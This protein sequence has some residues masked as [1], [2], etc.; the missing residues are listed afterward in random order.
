[1]EQHLHRKLEDT[2]LKWERECVSQTYSASPYSILTWRC[3]QHEACHCAGPPRERH[4]GGYAE[5][6]LGEG[7]EVE[8]GEGHHNGEPDSGVSSSV[9]WVVSAAVLIQRRGT[10]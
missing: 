6:P 9:T 2:K 7:R 5:A 1:M 8:A 4:P 3:S 10:L